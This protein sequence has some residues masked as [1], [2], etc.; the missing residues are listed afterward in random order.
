M[1]STLVHVTHPLI[2]VFKYFFWNVLILLM[3]PFPANIAFCHYIPFNLTA[4]AGNWN[5]QTLSNAVFWFYNAVINAIDNTP[6]FQP[7]HCL[8]TSMI[9]TSTVALL[10]RSRLAMEAAVSEAIKIIQFLTA[11]C[12]DKIPVVACL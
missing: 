5:R 1:P 10:E 2:V 7:F 12:R 11:N 9:F 8:C 4:R 6:Q 3:I